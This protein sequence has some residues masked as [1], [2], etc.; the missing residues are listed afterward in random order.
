MLFF[1]HSLCFFCDREWFFQNTGWE[2]LL[3]GKGKSDFIC[4]DYGGRLV[5]V[6]LIRLRDLRSALK[7]RAVR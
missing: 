2:K 7:G 4:N 6:L 3:T 1:R 5:D